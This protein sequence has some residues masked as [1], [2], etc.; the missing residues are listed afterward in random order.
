[1][2]GLPQAELN[3]LE[4]QFLLLNDFDLAITDE[5]METYAR[6][7]IDFNSQLAEPVESIPTA[8]SEYAAPSSSMG[9]Y[10]AYR[11]EDAYQTDTAETEQDDGDEAYEEDTVR[12]S[13]TRSSSFA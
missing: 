3:Q 6:R 5:E 10:D 2:G 11:S 4:L 13:S 8:F 9:A 7:L 1:M 12:P